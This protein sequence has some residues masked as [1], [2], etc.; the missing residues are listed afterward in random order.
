M[1]D[2]ATHHIP[3]EITIAIR[4]EEQWGHVLTQRLGFGNLQIAPEHASVVSEMG[5]RFLPMGGADDEI[6]LVIAID[7]SHGNPGA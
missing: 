1:L 7:V 2:T 5:V 4:I 6:V 3:I